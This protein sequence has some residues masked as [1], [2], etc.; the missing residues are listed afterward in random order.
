MRNIDIIESEST[1]KDLLDQMVRFQTDL[2]VSSIEW[3]ETFT[4][5]LIDLPTAWYLVK[6]PLKKEYANSWIK[7][8]GKWNH[9]AGKTIEHN[10]LGMAY[11]WWGCSEI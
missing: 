6:V 2:G 3:M 5:R 4:E 9:A 8:Y 11:A 1:K 7:A 10:Q